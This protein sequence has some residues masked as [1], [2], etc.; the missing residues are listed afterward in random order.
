MHIIIIIVTILYA[1]VNIRPTG[2]GSAGRLRILIKILLKN[3][4]KNKKNAYDRMP[5]NEFY[6]ETYPGNSRD[7]YSI[8]GGRCRDVSRMCTFFN[9]SFTIDFFL[10]VSTWKSLYYKITRNAEH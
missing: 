5:E 10:I 2:T 7:S 6:N 9:I 4:K 8:Y 3:K 1:H